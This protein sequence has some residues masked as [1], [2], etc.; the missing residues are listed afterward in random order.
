V[1]IPAPQFQRGTGPGALPFGEAAQA[2]RGVDLAQATRS[3]S[4]AS[5]LPPSGTAT[6]P[7]S[8]EPPFRPTTDAQKKLLFAPTDFPNEHV[9]TGIGSNPGGV[10]PPPSVVAALPA[11]RAAAAMPGP[12]QE[13]AQSLLVTLMHLMGQ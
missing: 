2:N 10:A 8:A 13:A 9:L 5:A 6:G 12:G 4:S 3:A 1:N 7:G 11:F